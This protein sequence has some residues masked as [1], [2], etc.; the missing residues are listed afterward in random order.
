MTEEKKRS[1]HKLSAWI[2]DKLYD[3]LQAL[4]YFGRQI[5]QTETITE[6]LELLLT[7]SQKGDKREIQGDVWGTPGDENNNLGDSG[8]LGELHVK[9]GDMQEIINEKDRHIE[10]LKEE[11]SKEERDKADL[12]EQLKLND[13]NQL[14]RITD[15]K[16]EI[17][18]LRNELTNKNDTIKNLTIITES[19]IKGYKLIEA[20]G[21]KKSWWRFW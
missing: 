20:P 5:S 14:L 11:L 3:D 21:A 12:K 18:V 4:G 7:E 10:T 19:Q 6:A 2:S 1:G 16:E 15:L 8:R 17:S 13:E 9:V